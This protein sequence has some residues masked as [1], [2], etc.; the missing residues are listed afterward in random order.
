M[1]NLKKRAVI[2]LN[3]RANSEYVI[4]DAVTNVQWSLVDSF[5][6]TRITQLLGIE[7]PRSVFYII[8]TYANYRIV[9]VHEI[10]TKLN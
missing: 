7:D 1:S 5:L 10:K 6:L 4:N 3:S 8:L 2:E 9:F